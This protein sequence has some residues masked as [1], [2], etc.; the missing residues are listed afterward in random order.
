EETHSPGFL[1]AVEGVIRHGQDVP[2]ERLDDPRE[3]A[4]QLSDAV[5]VAYR[6][7]G[8]RFLEPAPYVEALAASVIARGGEL[9]TAIAVTAVARD[10][11]PRVTLADGERLGA[12]S[13]VHA[14]GAWLPQ[15]AGALGVRTR[16]QAGRGYSSTV[17]TEEP[18][19]HP[20]SLPFQRIACTP[21]QEI[22]RASCRERA[23]A[24]AGAGA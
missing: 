23:E 8:Q 2:F 10:T 1:R 22:G 4:P 3:L 15:L 19:T 11:R 24:A 7:D 16:V 5:K 12:D 18:A 21:Y 6:L 13:V 9:R 20:V 14:T 17:A